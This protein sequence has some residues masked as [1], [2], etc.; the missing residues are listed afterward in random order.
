M[1]WYRPDTIW[2]SLVL[3]FGVYAVIDGV[4]A[5]VVAFKG[6]TRDR[7][8]DVL[9]GI[10]GI[11]VGLINFL[12]PVQARMAIVPVIGLGLPSPE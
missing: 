2:A 10:L 9:E 8:F 3:V 11:A 7:E 5:I 1:A 6:E 4:F 12:Y